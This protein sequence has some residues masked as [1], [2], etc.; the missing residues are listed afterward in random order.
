MDAIARVV[1]EL[2]RQ[3]GFGCKLKDFILAVPSLIKLGTIE[4]PVEI[5]HPEIWD[6]CTRAL[7]K[8]TM[9]SGS[10]KTLK[11][12]GRVIQALQK[13][14]Q[15]QETWK[16]TRTCL[17]ATLQLGIG[18]ATQTAADFDRAE[19][20]VAQTPEVPPW[21][22]GL[23]TPPEGPERARAFWQRFAEDAR[24]AAVVSELETAVE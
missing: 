2:H 23:D 6:K 12:W 17:L 9:S 11:S 24:N 4:S 18:A 14:R 21:S 19:L 22:P 1:S 15:E 8:E 10:G 3:L 5:L 16:A 13:A 7:A 20:A